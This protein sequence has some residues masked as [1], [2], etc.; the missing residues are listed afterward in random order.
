MRRL[1]LKAQASKDD[2]KNL[3]ATGK[4]CSPGTFANFVDCVIDTGLKSPSKQS[5]ISEVLEKKC[6]VNLMTDQMKKV[7]DPTLQL[8]SF[9]TQNRLKDHALLVDELKAEYG[10]LRKASLAL[11][12]PWKTFHGLCT[13]PVDHVK[14]RNVEMKEKKSVLD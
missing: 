7:P 12:V 4:V 1:Y 11:N 3:G 2:I 13:P 10:S 9:K 14:K 6:T 8:K 5:V